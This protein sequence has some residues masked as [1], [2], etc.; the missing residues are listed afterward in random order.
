MALYLRPLLDLE[1]VGYD[2][3]PMKRD[4]VTRLEKSCGRIRLVKP[5]GSDTRGGRGCGDTIRNSED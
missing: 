3:Y 4:T 2:R 5:K 1:E